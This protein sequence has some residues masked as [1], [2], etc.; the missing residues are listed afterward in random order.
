[1]HARSKLCKK[2]CEKRVAFVTYE[3]NEKTTTKNKTNILQLTQS[4]LEVHKSCRL[5]QK[6]IITTNFFSNIIIEITLLVM[7][8]YKKENR[9]IS[10]CFTLCVCTILACGKKNKNLHVNSQQ[11]CDIF[12]FSFFYSHINTYP[13]W[14]IL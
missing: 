10:K 5:I 7:A 11:E 9:K 2:H 6:K 3:E 8:K 12:C 4:K 13:E 14:W 1:M